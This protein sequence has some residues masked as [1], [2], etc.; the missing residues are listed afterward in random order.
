MTDFKIL[1]QISL[2]ESADGNVFE[3]FMTDRY[4]PAVR[5]GPTRLGVVTGLAL[6]RETAD[7]NSFLIQMDYNGAPV[8]QLV[9]TDDEIRARFEA[10]NA[11]AVRLAAYKEAAIHWPD[12]E[13]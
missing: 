9:V 7:P 11:P 8:G 1:Y 10:F 6:W 13:S 4:L 2:P 5:R 3:K 12:P